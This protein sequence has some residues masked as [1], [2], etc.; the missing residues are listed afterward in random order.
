MTSAQS[1]SGFFLRR[2]KPS[3]LAAALAFVLTGCNTLYLH[4]LSWPRKGKIVVGGLKSP[5]KRA[6]LLADPRRS[7]LPARRACELDV[8]VQGPARAPHPTDTVIALE[9]E[10]EPVTEL[11]NTGQGETAGRDDTSWLL[12]LSLTTMLGGAAYALRRRRAA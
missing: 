5:V 12:I 4:V 10:G 11:P 7:P 6:Y 9:M 1:Q 2:C 3:W 8:I